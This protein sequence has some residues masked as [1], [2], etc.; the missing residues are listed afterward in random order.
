MS[1]AAIPAD[2]EQRIL[3]LERYDI[4]DSL[5]EA[6]YD[7][8]T[9]LAAQICGTPISLVS[10]VASE[11]Q[12]FKSRHG[13][14]PGE[15][16]REIS[17]CA[18][19]IH[20][21]EVF[22][23][24][25]ATLDKRFCDNPLVTGEHHIR[26]YAGAPL[27]TPDGLKLG[28]LCVID[29]K[30]RE[31]LTDAQRAALLALARQAVALLEL[32]RSVARLQASNRELRDSREEFRSFMDNSPIVA[33]S[34]DAQ[35]RMTYANRTW[36]KNFGFKVELE[37]GITDFDWLP[38]DVAVAIR[39][40]DL[41]VLG[42]NR[43][44]QTI[45]Q[46]PT[47]ANPRCEWLV[48][49]F[50]IGT[51]DDVRL[52]GVALDLTELRRAEKLKDEFI[53]VVSHELRTPL[54]ALRGSLGLLDNQVA[55]TLPLQASEM[56]KLALKNAERLALLI[57]DLLDM[58]KIENGAMLFEMKE[59]ALEKLLHD[60][61]ELNAA[62]AA[63]LSVRLRLEPLPA[64]LRGA[65]VSGDINRLL[66]VLANLL[67]N[68]A[69]FTRLPGAVHLR[70]RLIESRDAFAPEGKCVRIEV[71]D[72]GAGVPAEFVPRLFHRFAQA[73]TSA[74]RRKGGTGLGLAISRA[75]IEKHGTRIGYEP[76]GENCAG[77]TFFF[78][79][80]LVE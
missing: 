78:E 51:G 33:F 41:L 63:T 80:R 79:L 71:C 59:F 68:A 29:R 20:G 72:E 35:G 3:A 14:G 74:T 42:E 9:S 64:E 17:F 66:Q 6:Q 22:E 7:D 52:G 8:L 19:A 47:P 43:V 21:E 5:P 44:L 40:N 61:I 58:E 62:Y 13:F 10:L 38:L 69:K 55:G 67:S 77:A 46:V 56:V 4:L 24:P 76:P 39:E 75:I 65:R 30:P 36:E 1:A 34:K 37:R 18:H 27:V 12:W 32:R 60:A 48:F 26:F 70:A 73:D 54:T 25:D 53:A 15:S 50:P 23:V 57:N 2:E 45:E 28:T 49:K 11:R 16:P 31:K